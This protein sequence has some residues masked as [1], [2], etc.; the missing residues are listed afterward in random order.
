M[1]GDDPFTGYSD[2]WES[3]WWAARSRSGA[4]AKVAK[5][6]GR[7]RGETS[8]GERW[9][10]RCARGLRAYARWGGG[11]RG[12]L[13]RRGARGWVPALTPADPGRGRGRRGAG[14]RPGTA[15]VGERLRAAA[16][17]ARSG[18]AQRGVA[19]VLRRGARVVAR[20]RGSGASAGSESGVSGAL[21]SVRAALR[22]PGRRRGSFGARTQRRQP[23]TMGAWSTRAG[24]CPVG[25][26]RPPSSGPGKLEL[27]GRWDGLRR[28][29]NVLATSELRLRSAVLRYTAATAYELTGS[30]GAEDQ[31]RALRLQ[32]FPRRGG[33]PPGHRRAVLT[34]SGSSR[35]QQTRRSCVHGANAS[36]FD[37]AEQRQP[38]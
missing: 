6:R 4:A 38:R 25:R 2:G 1:V 13:A 34:S 16:V 15:D 12:V 20:G 23:R 27:I 18:A 33:G 5:G 35:E 17:G 9:V 30:A 11:V 7:A 29:G 19:G 28:V 22:E 32:R 37:P 3:R 14:A 26:P 31:R 36:R 8:G 24:S 10:L 21:E